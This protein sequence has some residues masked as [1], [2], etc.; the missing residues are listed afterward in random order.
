MFP[1]KISE[2]SQEGECLP[3]LLYTLEYTARDDS[4]GNKKRYPSKKQGYRFLGVMSLFLVFGSSGGLFGFALGFFGKF[5]ALRACG[6]FK[7]LG[8]FG[9][10]LE[11]I[12]ATG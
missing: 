5:D 9:Q 8:L 7:S 1:K 6:C 10:F 12:H 11:P 3:F 2:R 4:E